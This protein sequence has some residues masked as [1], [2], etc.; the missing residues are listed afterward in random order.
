MKDNNSNIGQIGNLLLIASVIGCLIYF[1]K[2]QTTQ[3][4]KYRGGRRGGGRRGG[5]RRGGG[6]RGGRR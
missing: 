3:K 6:R 5:G 4:E 1:I 2:T